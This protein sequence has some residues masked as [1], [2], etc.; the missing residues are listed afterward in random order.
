M[1]VAALLLPGLGYAADLP[2]EANTVLAIQAM[3]TAI[4]QAGIAEQQFERA[5]PE[6]GKNIEALKEKAAT[7][8][9]WRDACL[10]TPECGGKKAPDLP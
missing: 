1:I 9:Y 5:F 8:D 4:K 10:S 6:F 7:S 3:Q 2:Q